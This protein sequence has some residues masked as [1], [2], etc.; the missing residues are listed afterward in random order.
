LISTKLK[1]E[2]KKLGGAR[3]RKKKQLF[4]DGAELERMISGGG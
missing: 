1:K 3:P 2:L 4:K